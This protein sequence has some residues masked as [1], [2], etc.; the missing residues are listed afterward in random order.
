[1]PLILNKVKK[2]SINFLAYNKNLSNLENFFSNLCYEAK[3]VYVNNETLG[4]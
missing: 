3:T 4:T 2:N 1:M